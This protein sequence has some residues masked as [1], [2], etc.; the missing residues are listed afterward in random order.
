MVDAAGWDGVG[1]VRGMWGVYICSGGLLA[2]LRT[3]VVTLSGV[4]RVLLWTGLEFVI[5]QAGIC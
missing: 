3:G 4:I 2:S 5:F 1:L